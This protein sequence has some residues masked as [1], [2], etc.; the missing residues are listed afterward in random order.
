MNYSYALS[1]FQ[2][3]CARGDLLQAQSTYVQREGTRALIGACYNGHLT[4][5]Q[6]LYGL[7]ADIRTGD[8]LLSACGRGHLAVAQ[9]LHGLGADVR[10]PLMGIYAASDYSPEVR[11]WLEVASKP[12]MSQFLWPVPEFGGKTTADP[13]PVCYESLEGFVGQL[14]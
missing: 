3:A 2:L 14:P 6:W 8:A 7:D 13:C 4:V 1:E 9:W 12:D 10:M 11:Q 5:A